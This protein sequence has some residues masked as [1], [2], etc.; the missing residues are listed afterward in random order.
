MP[1][2]AQLTRDRVTSKTSRINRLIQRLAKRSAPPLPTPASLDYRV[3]SPD[4]ADVEI[5]EAWHDDLVAGTQ[6]A[7][8]RELLTQMYDGRPRRDLVVAGQ[9]VSMTG[10]DKPSLL[11]VGCGSGYYAIVLDHLVSQPVRYTG[12]DFSQS[13]TNLARRR[14][15][16]HHFVCGD[17]TQLPWADASFDIVFNGVSLMHIA[18]YAAA[19]AE[20][21][22]VA[23][24][25]CILHTVPV[26]Q[27]RP[28]TML[29]KLAYGKPVI[30]V[31]F[32]QRSLIELL[33]RHDLKVHDAINSVDYDLKH[34]VGEPTTTKTFVC[35]RH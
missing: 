33:G 18:D 7:A 35:R 29:R 21:S 4:Q 25:W 3:L 11:D 22:R 30:E 28:T 1:K 31:I 15:P 12:L 24:S 16:Q 9:A 2:D 27:E 5:G 10:L 17:A 8:Y 26:M 32:N 23:R 19:I 14:Q 20:A 34:V 13:M 6:D